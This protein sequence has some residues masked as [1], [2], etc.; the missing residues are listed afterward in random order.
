M[1]R[2]LHV[3]SFSQISEKSGIPILIPEEKTIN[4]FHHFSGFR[5]SKF[6]FTGKD[7]SGFL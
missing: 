1:K 2:N 5:I 3:V 6:D 4:F 7:R